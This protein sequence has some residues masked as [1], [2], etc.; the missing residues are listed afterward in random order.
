MSNVLG[1]ITIFLVV[2]IAGNQKDINHL[3]NEQVEESC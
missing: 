2:T 3:V 1:S